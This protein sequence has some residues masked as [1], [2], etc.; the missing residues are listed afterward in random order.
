M[1]YCSLKNQRA[2]GTPY[3][4][5]KNDRNTIE[6]CQFTRQI[7]GPYKLENVRRLTNLTNISEG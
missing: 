1:V 6:I 5:T 4:E 7:D 3:Q 2:K